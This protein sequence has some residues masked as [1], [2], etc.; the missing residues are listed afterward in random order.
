[1]EHL[2]SQLGT[3]YG[4]K[5][6]KFIKIHQQSA[7]LGSKQLGSFEITEVISD[8]DYR[9]ALPPALKIHDVFHVNCLSPYKGNDVNGLT[10]SPP[11]PVTVHGKEEYEVDHIRDSELFGHTLK[12]LVC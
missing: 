12:Y 10:P 1:M 7:K 6:S 2:H 11:D 4:F 5:Q 9:L 8:V 3:K